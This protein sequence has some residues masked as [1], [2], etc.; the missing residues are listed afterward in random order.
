MLNVQGLCR[1]IRGTFLGD[2][3]SFKSTNAWPGL[4]NRWPSVKRD[5]GFPSILAQNWTTLWG[6][7][8]VNPIN[9]KL[10]A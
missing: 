8:P 4:E 3:K 10:K 2:F 1:S 5:A 6:I 9:L 7:L